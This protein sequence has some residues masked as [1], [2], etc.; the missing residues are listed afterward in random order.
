M[1]ISNLQIDFNS[2]W[3]LMEGDFVTSVID[4][5]SPINS[6]LILD[7][8]YFVDFPV[9]DPVLMLLICLLMYCDDSTWYIYFFISIVCYTGPSYIY[10][11]KR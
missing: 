8:N 10:V 1:A 9:K 4:S 6:K 2:N 7:G 3:L 11:D 5:I